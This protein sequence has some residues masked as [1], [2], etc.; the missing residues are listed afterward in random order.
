MRGMVVFPYMTLNF[1]AG[2]DVSIK[3]LEAAVDEGSLVFLAAQKDASNENPKLDDIHNIGTIAK[4]KQV[5]N[6]PGGITRVVVGGIRRGAIRE[7][8][9][10]QKYFKSV[11]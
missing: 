8:V 4:I 5:L 11:I 7:L 9:S 2:R 3:A 10:S 1:D 6:M